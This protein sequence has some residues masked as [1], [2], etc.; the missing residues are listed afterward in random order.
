MA[1]AR[2]CAGLFE[3]AFASPVERRL[4]PFRGWLDAQAAITLPEV[5]FLGGLARSCE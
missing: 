1:E 5:I 2:E 3:E 4:V